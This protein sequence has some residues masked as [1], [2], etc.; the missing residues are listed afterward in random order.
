MRRDQGFIEIT[1][2][3][4]NE[5]YSVITPY[6]RR[7]EA[8]DNVKPEPAGL[9]RQFRFLIKK[10]KTPSVRRTRVRAPT[11]TKGQTDDDVPRMEMTVGV[12]KIN[13]LYTRITDGQMESV[14][15]S[16]PLRNPREPLLTGRGAARPANHARV[17]CCA[18]K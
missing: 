15:T 17:L 2:T 1:S 14:T 12:R 3:V 8:A 18:A 4:K 7:N 10:K 5:A 11:R 6:L 16:K 13:V 9:A